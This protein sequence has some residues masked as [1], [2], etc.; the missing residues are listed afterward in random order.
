MTTDTKEARSSVLASLT[1]EVMADK[2]TEARK[3]TPVTGEKGGL[4]LERAALPNDV[5]VFMSNEA[6]FTHAKQLRKFASD[7]IAIADGLDV[8]LAASS[9][10]APHEDS[11]EVKAAKQKAIERLADAKAA[12][13]AAAQPDYIDPAAVGQVAEA[14]VAEAEPE[15]EP[16]QTTF[17]EDFAAKAKA[18]QDATFTKPSEPEPVEDGWKCSIHGKAVT[19]TSPKTGRE[20]IGCPDCNQFAR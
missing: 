20:F 2:K 15:A 4:P 13:R 1:A 17:A 19:K 6:L 16:E 3:L 14:E 10:E 8:M 5:G 12:E 18:A 11:P 9:I 7:A